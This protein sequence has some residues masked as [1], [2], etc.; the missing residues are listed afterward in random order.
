MDQLKSI[1]GREIQRHGSR[2]KKECLMEFVLETGCLSLRWEDSLV[3]LDEKVT[4]LNDL[5]GSLDKL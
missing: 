3:E 5:V 1:V 2:L 4:M